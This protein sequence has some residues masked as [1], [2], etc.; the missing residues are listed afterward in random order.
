MPTQ[1]SSETLKKW[2]YH[3]VGMHYGLSEADDPS[4]DMDGLSE[5]IARKIGG[6]TAPSVRGV[7]HGYE[8]TL[9]IKPDK[10]E[11]FAI[12]KIQ[13]WVQEHHGRYYCAQKEGTKRL[14]YPI[15]GEEFA[16]YIYFNF[17]ME[18]DHAT[19]LSTFLNVWDMSL[20]YLLIRH[21][22]SAYGGAN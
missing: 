8:L 5:Y 22:N 18:L 17:D 7:R 19:A 1:I 2:I 11:D 10:D 21:D 15:N 13:E 3:W 20:R 4:W 9:L 16:K 6:T 12:R 14:A